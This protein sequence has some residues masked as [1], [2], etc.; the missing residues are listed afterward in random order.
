[1]TDWELTDE[2]WF[3][4]R[5]A[6]ALLEPEEHGR[7]GIAPVHEPD[8]DTIHSGTDLVAVKTAAHLTSCGVVVELGDARFIPTEIT[9]RTAGVSWKATFEKAD[10]H[11]VWYEMTERDDD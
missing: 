6:F 1:M 5:I 10:R 3:R 8:P 4:E 9:G 11:E 7:C 2:Q